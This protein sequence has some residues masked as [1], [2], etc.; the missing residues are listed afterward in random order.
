MRW[1]VWVACI[2]ACAE[3]APPPVAP[4]PVAPTPVALPTSTEVLERVAHAYAAAS[5]YVDRGVV[6][7][8][9]T[10]AQGG[11]TK[12]KPFETAF[13]RPS[14]FRFEFRDDGKS[15]RAFTIWTEGDRA[16]SRWFVTGNRI[17]QARNLSFAIAGATGVSSGSAYTVPSL[18][19]PQ[20]L[21]GSKVLE[22]ADARVEG[23]ELIDGHRCYRVTGKRIG[24]SVRTLWIDVESRARHRAREQRGIA[25]RV[26]L[27]SRRR[28]SAVRMRFSA[29]SGTRSAIDA[30]RDQIEQLADVGLGTRS[31][32]RS[33]A[34]Q[35]GSDRVPSPTSASCSTRHDRR[36]S[37]PLSAENRILTALGLR[38]LQSRTRPGIAALLAARGVDPTRRSTRA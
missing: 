7:D 14:R 10:T 26:L 32:S 33:R 27:C 8:R 1:L 19:M 31:T 16:F 20:E 3:K 5:T 2:A 13:E 35:A 24:D 25:G 23:V 15:A 9:F 37:C 29:D 28:P 18:L 36:I 4:T 38:R 34:V 17:E 30:E 21:T 12:T 22:L 11:R 6:T